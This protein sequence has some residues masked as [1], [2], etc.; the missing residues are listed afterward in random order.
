MQ[1]DDALPAGA[2]PRRLGVIDRRVED[3]VRGVRVRRPRAALRQKRDQTAREVSL[4]RGGLAAALPRERIRGERGHE[5]GQHRNRRAVL[6]HQSRGAPAVGQH[7]D[8]R[9]A[10][11]LRRSHSAR[12]ERLEGLHGYG[13][14]R[15]DA[16]EQLVVIDAHLRL[17]T[18]LAHHPHRVH[19][20]GTGRRLPGEHH[21]V[22]AVED[23]V[24][25]VG[26]LGAGGAG[27]AGH[28]L[29]HLGGGDDGLTAEVGLSDHHLLDPEY[30][31][32]GDLHAEVAAGHHD[33]VGVLED[34][35][36]VC[37]ALLV[38]DLGDDL[39]LVTTRFIEDLAD[40]LH[41]LAGLHERGGDKVHLVLAAEV[42]HVVDILFGEHG[43]IDLDAGKV[44]VLALA[45]LL[46]VE[47]GALEDCVALDV[48]DTDR[49]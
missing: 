11:L 1:R 24:G 17:A 4:P 14:L 28:G 19:R 22:G 37:D 8:E 18:Y 13:H 7:H 12:R 21:A 36:K 3:L 40:Q 47:H 49:D 34:V 9:R 33:A 27:R 32:Q 25:D 41:V 30:S 2:V 31:L 48:V 10:N 38:L 43:D 39:D 5:H 16:L 42:L 23:G 46:G 35:V 20:E 44:A 15:E 45:E 26:G 29:E 6:G